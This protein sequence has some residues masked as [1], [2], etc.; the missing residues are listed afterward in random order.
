MNNT[1]NYQTQLTTELEM[2]TAYLNELFAEMEAT[3]DDYEADRL[4]RLVQDEVEY[5][6]EV[7]DA[8]EYGTVMTL[9]FA[10]NNK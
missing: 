8:V 1:A 10:E 2:A 3:D 7:K 4:M 9:R 5:V 6:K